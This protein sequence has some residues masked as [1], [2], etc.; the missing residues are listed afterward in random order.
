MRDYQQAADRA[1]LP[2]PP[3]P[4]RHPAADFAARGQDYVDA[5]SAPGRSSPSPDRWC[6]SDE[7]VPRTRA[8]TSPAA[9]WS[10]PWCSCA[11]PCRPPR[12]RSTCPA[13]TAQR[14][15]RQRDGRPARGLRH[16]AADDAR[17]AAARRRRRLDRRRQV[18]AGQLPRRAPGHRAGRAAAH[19]PLAG[20]GAPPRRRR[21]VR[22]RTGCCPT[23]SGSTTPTNDPDA[24]QLVPDATRCPQGWR[25]STPPTSTRSRSA[26]A[27]SPPSC[28]PPPTC[29]CSSPRPRATPT[30][31]RG[32][33][34]GRPP[35]APPR[36]RSSSTAPRP[37]RSRPS[38]PTWPGCSPAAGSRTR[39]CSRSPRARSATTG[40][41]RP[42]HVAEIRGW[43]DS[44]AADAERPRA[45]VQ[46]T[47]EGASA[48]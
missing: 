15:H 9:R 42:S 48:P 21:V 46:Q 10:P 6:P 38:P 32:T 5:I 4:A 13:S 29:G 45:V 16:P 17:R 37:R 27:P 35:S 19:H 44:L 31:C 41:C 40:C 11:A 23:S 43:L 30:R 1:R 7:H 20:A 33:S 26:T 8:R 34:C 25:S 18:D 14:G 2:P 39:R 47:L 36:S 28:S 24:L 22:A 12:C 3:L